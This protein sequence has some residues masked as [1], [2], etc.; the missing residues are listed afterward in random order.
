[1]GSSNHNSLVIVIVTGFLA[2]I[3]CTLYIVVAG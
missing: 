2:L 3:A 1:M